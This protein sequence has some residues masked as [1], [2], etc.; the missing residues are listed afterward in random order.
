MLPLF[1]E[2][3]VV[4]DPRLDRPTLL[5]RR[6][7]HLAHLRQHLLIR[8]GRYTDKMQQRLVLGRRPCRSRLRR[9]RFHALA[10]ARQDQAGTIIAQWAS[11]VR[12]PDNARK[13]L[14][15]RRKSCVGVAFAPQIH[16]ST[17]RQS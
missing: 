5:H 3:R 2:S 1:G 12:V 7:H 17:S 9:H 6:Q 4:D 13:S 16:I 15:I 14:Y 10:L 11:P 8:P